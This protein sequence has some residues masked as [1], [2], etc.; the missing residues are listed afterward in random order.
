MHTTLGITFCA[1]CCGVRSC[2]SII[3]GVGVGLTST[4]SSKAE[5]LPPLSWWG[6]FCGESVLCVGFCAIVCCGEYILSFLTNE[7]T[8]RVIETRETKR[9]A[10][11]LKT[12]RNYRENKMQIFN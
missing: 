1:A 12:K 11:Q 9:V 3:L 6:V 7:T 10:K 4:I 2:P 8:Q 5:E